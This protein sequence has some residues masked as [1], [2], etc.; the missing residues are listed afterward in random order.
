[1]LPRTWILKGVYTCSA[2]NKAPLHKG[3]A[4][5][6]LSHPQ[7]NPPEEACGPAKINRKEVE[8]V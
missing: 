7:K 8:L 2:D 4:A 6:S 3:E 1:M 5:L